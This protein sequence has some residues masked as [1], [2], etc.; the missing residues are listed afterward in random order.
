VKEP[1]FV[2]SPY[3]YDIKAASTEAALTCPEP[4]LTVQ[5]DAEDADINTIVRRFGITGHLPEN[6]RIPSY[7]DFTDVHDFQSAQNAIRH[8]QEQFDALP[9][10]VRAAFLNDPQR[11]LEAAE[12]PDFEARFAAAF[13]APDVKQDVPPP[14]RRSAGLTIALLDV[15]GH[16]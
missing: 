5:A 9:A 16:R 11:L 8:A 13:R 3:N 15:N 2:R 14:G 10:E 7:G 4:S 1:P 6:A 12:Q